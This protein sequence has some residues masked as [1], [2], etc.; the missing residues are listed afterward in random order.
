MD[1]RLHQRGFGIKSAEAQRHQSIG[2]RARHMVCGMESNLGKRAW[3][4]RQGS[5][6]IAP[7]QTCAWGAETRH[8]EGQVRHRPA[9]RT[10]V[11]DCSITDGLL[12]R[13]AM[14]GTTKPA[15]LPRWIEIGKGRRAQRF[16]ERSFQ[17]SAW[18]MLPSLYAHVIFSYEAHAHL[19]MHVAPE[20]MPAQMLNSDQVSLGY[21][22]QL[23]SPHTRGATGV[24]TRVQLGRWSGGSDAGDDAR[25]RAH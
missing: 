8:D 18:M 3:P 17:L 13:H 19:E 16:Y 23:P 20:L 24:L 7:S 12:L 4:L 11:K 21:T 22:T 5:A 6:A 10:T 15:P 25:H 9:D 1:N 2:R 14:V